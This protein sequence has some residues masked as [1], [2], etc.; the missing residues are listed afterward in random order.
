MLVEFT[1]DDEP[2]QAG[3][4]TA[5]PKLS[6]SH[7][8]SATCARSF[9]ISS[10]A[11]PSACGSAAGFITKG[12]LGS[13]E[14]VLGILT[15]TL[16]ADEV[17]RCIRK[18]VILVK[19]LGAIEPE[20]LQK[21]LQTLGRNMENAKTHKPPGTFRLLRGL[22]NPET[23]RV[24]APFVKATRQAGRKLHLAPTGRQKRPRHRTTRH[25]A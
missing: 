20:S 22:L 13:G 12:L 21:I 4:K 17:V 2:V 7:R 23:R 15:E 6:I 16:E 14:K 19:V 11:P 5:W 25:C 8:L 9:A 3:S 1:L 18:L 10:N 24:V